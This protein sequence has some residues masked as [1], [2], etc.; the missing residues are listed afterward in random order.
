MKS[1]QFDYPAAI[2][3]M[4]FPL[5]LPQPIS[6]NLKKQKC[7]TA[8]CLPLDKKPSC[9]IRSRLCKPTIQTTKSL[10]MSE[11]PSTG[12]EKV[13]CPFYDE[14]VRE[15]S[16]ALWLPTLTGCV[17]Q[18]SHW[19]P[20]SFKNV[21]RN[22][23]FTI[24]KWTPLSSSS[25]T[26]CLQR[27]QSLSADCMAGVR[28]NIGPTDEELSEEAKRAKKEGAAK[29][30]EEKKR[31]AMAAAAANPKKQKTKTPRQLEREAVVLQ[32]RE[33]KLA[34]RERK[35]KNREAARGG[36]EAKKPVT[37]AQAKV[38][39]KKAA[40]KM[41][42]ATASRTLRLRPSPEMAR[43]LKMWSGC[44]RVIYNRALALSR[45]T[46]PPKSY[47]YAG[48]IRNAVCN[49]ENIPEPWL[50]N[51]PGGCRKLAAKDLCDAFWSNKAKQSKNFDH[52]FKLRFKS[53]KDSSQVLKVEHAHLKVDMER[54]Q[55]RICP[56]KAKA[57]IVQ[58][59]SKKQ[60]KE[61]DERMLNVW[62]DTSQLAG[63]VRLDKDVVVTMDKLGRFWMH[64]PYSRE[65]PE[66][67]RQSSRWT[68]LDPGNRVFLTGYDPSGHAF[69]LG[70]HASN[71]IVRLCQHLDSLVSKTDLLD[72][73]KNKERWHGKKKKRVCQKVARMRKAQQRLRYR[74][75]DLVTELHWKCASWLCSRY[76]DIIL[77][78]FPTQ[79]MVCKEGGRC[80][81]SK[82]ARG[83]M[84]FSHFTFRQ[85]L[86]HTAS[87]TGSK[88]YIRDEDYT[89]KTCTNCGTIHDGLGSSGVF[90]CPRCHVKAC[91][92]G[93]AA[94][95]IFLKNT[96][97]AF[98][99]TKELC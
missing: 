13:F 83:L 17:E 6:K 81:R 23:W 57:Q 41:N 40:K 4:T 35:R 7:V 24:Q 68:A 44:Y 92:D 70:T 39:V 48:F 47:N 90:K 74:I 55:L 21:E 12:T 42:A 3:G 32:K 34:D 22:S 52:E 46:K 53:K 43:V 51:L 54:G 76:T 25:Q 95:N 86:I 98:V 78:K 61:F 64:C 56:A 80:I 14:R 2:G 1:H 30:A 18:P 16:N 85:R 66:N 33:A 49:A 15:I 89:S 27:S 94:R 65:M 63:G 50:Q 77:P 36:R 62:F 26:N 5:T 96:V 58:F 82:T 71:R 73:H 60:A 29:R 59:C 69:K 19:S 99:D 38:L 84:T 79:Q 67:Q 9:D 20:G 75:K 37:D 87:M 31:K 93:A 97:L 91:R 88:V 28:I 72:S 8:E 10:L 11:A 45:A